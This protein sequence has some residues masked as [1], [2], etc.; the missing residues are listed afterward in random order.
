[1]EP[2]FKIPISLGTPSSLSDATA[3]P[4]RPYVDPLEAPPP[5]EVPIGDVPIVSAIPISNPTQQLPAP[6][7]PPAPWASAV[8][9][10]PVVVGSSMAH[11]GGTIWEGDGS[12][13]TTNRSNLYVPI[14][15]VV[16]NIPNLVNE[17]TLAI[18][19]LDTC[20]KWIRKENWSKM[21]TNMSP[22]EYSSVIK[23]VSI[24]FDQPE[25][26]V[27]IA[28][29]IRSFTHQYVIAAIKSCSNW[30]RVDM[31]TKLLPYCEDLPTNGGLI[32]EELNDWER[33]CTEREFEETLRNR[34]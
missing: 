24:E 25:V 1:M 20:R 32:R 18:S 7:A 10:S 27:L 26:A 17:I 21:F 34:Y 30:L 3:L 11:V 31:V 22:T 8:T 6:S 5:P 14:A 33:V 19:P 2:E 4:S 16:P 28:P 15:E 23:A 12:A 9:A 29:E 13:T